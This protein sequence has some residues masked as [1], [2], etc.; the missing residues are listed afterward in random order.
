MPIVAAEDT[1]NKDWSKGTIG[2]KLLLKMGWKEGS[3]LGRD[4]QGTAQALRAVRKFDDAGIGAKEADSTGSQ[5]WN[6]TTDSFANVLQS[7]QVHHATTADDDDDGE[8][9]NGGKKKKKK[10]KKLVLA[11]NKVTAGHSRKMR[12]AKDL[13]TKSDYDMAAIFG[14]PVLKKKKTKRK[15]TEKVAVEK[16]KEDVPAASIEEEVSL[17]EDRRDETKKTRRKK[18][19]KRLL[20]TTKVRNQRR[21]SKRRTRN[22]KSL[23]CLGAAKRIVS[24]SLSRRKKKTFNDCRTARQRKKTCRIASELT[25]SHTHT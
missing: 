7:L 20:K 16:E 22:N 6:K 17:S 5:G 25:N 3:G 12:E 13:K 14:G 4:Q 23:V 10:R 1:R 15:R 19:R 18:T 9:T 8:T 2:S 24:D 11:Q 21:R